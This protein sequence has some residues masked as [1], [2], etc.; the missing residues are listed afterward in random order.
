LTCQASSITVDHVPDMEKQ[1]LMNLLLL[2]AISLPTVSMVVP[3]DSFFVPYGS[4]S[5]LDRLN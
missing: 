1:K 5:P 4:A 3:Y 2:D